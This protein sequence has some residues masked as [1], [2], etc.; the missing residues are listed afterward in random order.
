MSQRA[1]RTCSCGFEK[2][3]HKKAGKGLVPR[4]FRLA[5]G[6]YRAVRR[7]DADPAFAASVITQAVTQNA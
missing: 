3:R 6:R 4:D 1:Q 7:V 5:I 2:P